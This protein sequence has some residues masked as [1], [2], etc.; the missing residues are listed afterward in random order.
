MLSVSR[1]CYS[2]RSAD[3]F[4]RYRSFRLCID[5]SACLLMVQVCSFCRKERISF[6]G[7]SGN[8]FKSFHTAQSLDEPLLLL[9]FVTES[10]RQGYSCQMCSGKISGEGAYYQDSPQQRCRNLCHSGLCTFPVSSYIITPGFH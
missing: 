9:L 1:I 2:M 4:F 8:T 7:F 6:W 3:V 5:C 10:F